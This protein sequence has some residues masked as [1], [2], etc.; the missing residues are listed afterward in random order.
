MTLTKRELEDLNEALQGRV[1]ELTAEN[2]GLTCSLASA[3]E[4]YTQLT[5]RLTR[6]E[7]RYTRLKRL[8]TESLSEGPTE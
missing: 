7:Q 3:S 4:Q 5:E 2:W 1:Q 6:L 8:L